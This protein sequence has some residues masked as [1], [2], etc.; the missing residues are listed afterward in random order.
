MD[1]G[2]LL[3]REQIFAVHDTPFE[4][5][6]VPQW[7]GT[8]RVKTMNVPE[9]L[10]FSE[11][12]NRPEF[13]DHFREALVIACAVD[14]HDQPIFAAEDLPQMVKR[15]ARAFTAVFN[16]AAKLNGFSAEAVEGAAKNS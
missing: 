5:V 7:G 4:E 15:N 13:E 3:T 10:A 8:V 6:R 2:G 14:D 12:L 1:N 9:G 11:L 16:V